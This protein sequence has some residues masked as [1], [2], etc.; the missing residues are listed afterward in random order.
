[1]PAAVAEI[2]YRAQ[3]LGAK[4]VI[5]FVDEENIASLKGLQRAGFI[6]YILRKERW[7][8]FKRSVQ[9][10]PMTHECLESYSAFT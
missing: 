2:S 7:F 4:Y 5:A 6:P 3:K 9:F 8:L 1:M 10:C